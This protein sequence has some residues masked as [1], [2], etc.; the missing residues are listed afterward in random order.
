MA[1]RAVAK[2][3]ATR[4]KEA[5]DPQGRYDELL[6]RHTVQ[7]DQLNAC[8]DLLE[9]VR[10]GCIMLEEERVARANAAARRSLGSDPVGK[11]L[12]EIFEQE[13]GSDVVDRLMAA[14]VDMP[15][16]LRVIGTRARVEAFIVG[17]RSKAPTHMR[18]V[19]H[20]QDANAQVLQELGRSRRFARALINSSLDMIMAGDTE[21]RITEYNPAA[22]LRFGWE[23]EEVLG[24]STTM[25]YADP[26][27][28][29]KV[30]RELDEHGVFTGEIV[31]IT[32]Y[33]ERFTSF[34]AASRLYDEDGT[35]IGAMG[36]SRDI[37]RM[38]QDQEALRA[39]EA[40][41]R[42]LFETGE[43]MFWTTDRTLKLTSFNTGYSSM[44]E[45]LYG[46]KPEINTN[47]D[48]PRKLFAPEEYHRFWEK[49]YT[50][51]FEGGR[52]VRFET[53]RR[54]VNGVR[55]CNEVFL[56]PVFGSDGQVKEVFGIGHEITEQKEAEDLIREQSARLEAIFQ[57]AA[58][59]M[60]WTL[61]HR[62][63]LTSYNAHFKETI[64]REMG[65]AF[66][67]GDDF[68]VMR[69]RLADGPDGSTAPR[70]VAAM[71]G[72]PQQFEAKL[73]ARDGRTVWVEVFLNP[74]VINGQVTE[75]S[76]MAYG[77]TDR[78]EAEMK[79]LQSL[80]EKE[81]LLKEVHHRVKN[82]LQV[83]SSILSLQS[84]HVGDDKRLQDLLRDSRDRIRSMSFIHES[85]YQNKD[86]SSIDLAAYI[87][88]LA[89]NLMMSY[90]LTGKV[91][92][93]TDLVR[94]DLVLDQAIPCGLILNELIG[95]SLKH[96][97]P[98][99]RE[100]E[101]HIRLSEQDGQVSIALRDNGVGLPEGFDPKRDGNLGMELIDTLVDQL[102][103]SI[104]ME[105]RQGVSY[106]LTFERYQ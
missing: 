74:I 27:D 37:T 94:T 73:S 96:A 40:K 23:R 26:D 17:E 15:A 11:R 20:E 69:D 22:S 36:V 93:K 33:G 78:K 102:G 6:R 52:P 98:D 45:R 9:H 64:E 66:E 97:F 92:L 1:K 80:A 21:G 2:E 68:A 67:T 63:R 84:A 54:D 24:L 106:L 39:N 30:Q 77:I 81:V 88:G 25:L 4:A 72:K 43:H 60:I 103:G 53:E 41:L 12:A 34:L 57:N 95:N 14:S 99:L 61:D 35:Y 32:K 10:D 55:V 46:R 100:G 31:N 83:V 82:N 50:E 89:R 5:T 65:F 76:C 38:K 71:N 47:V 48:K 87:E 62:F 105:A 13:E 101:I 58:N 18:L 7:Q 8:W 16:N 3:N 59:V 44:I 104:V 70:Y 28:Y 75:I 42:A 29:H 91:E 85:L 19:M 79:L 90:S 86:F 56:T 51:V 49:K